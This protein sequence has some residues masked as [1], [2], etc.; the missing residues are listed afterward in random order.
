MKT[1]AVLALCTPLLALAAGPNVSTGVG[2]STSAANAQAISG[3]GGQGGKGGSAQ[4]NSNATGGQGGQGGSSTSQGGTSTAS[5]A[6]T[7]TTS[8]NEV[9]QTAGAWAAALAVSNGTCMGSTSGGAQG[10]GF[11]LSVGTTWN[12]EGCNRRYNAQQL[13]ALGQRSAALA[14]MCQDANVARAMEEAGDHCPRKPEVATPEITDPVI[15]KR[16]GLA[17]L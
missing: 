5:N 6:S 12:D 2:V 13:A 10:P 16:L 1:L 4:S 7:N 11:G 8:F 14:L 15:R 17:P 3:Q 9:R